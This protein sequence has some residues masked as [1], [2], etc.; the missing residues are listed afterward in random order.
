MSGRKACGGD[1]RW[2]LEGGEAVK[3][4]G[5]VLAG[6]VVL[7]SGAARTESVLARFG[8]SSCFARIYD[9]AHLARH[10]D[11]NVRTI[12]LSRSSAGVSGGK[13][14]LIL[15]FKVR[16][17]GETYSGEAIC[18]PRGS[19]A[20]CTLEGDAGRFSLAAKGDDLSMTVVRVSVEGEKDFAE[21]GADD[22]VFLLRKAA[23]VRCF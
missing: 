2:F 12:A 5:A 16:Q 7:A 4:S 17:S 21:F 11:Q 14:A 13:T 6:A 22:R 9:K 18:S 1:R 20:T 15:N 10:P 23:S 19:D 8:G 3:V